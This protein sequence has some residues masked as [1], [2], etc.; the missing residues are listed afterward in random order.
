[1]FGLLALYRQSRRQL[2]LVPHLVHLGQNRRRMRR[3]VDDGRVRRVRRPCGL[4][5]LL[6]RP[7]CR[8]RS[9]SFA[10]AACHVVG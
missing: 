5:A 9:L 1:M 4:V 10:P 2:A 8:R 3:V 7:P 6:T